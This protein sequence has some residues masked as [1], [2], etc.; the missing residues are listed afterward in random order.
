MSARFCPVSDDPSLR[1][2]LNI[3]QESRPADLGPGGTPV[4]F[5]GSRPR[6]GFSIEARPA[7]WLVKYESPCDAFRA[8]G[9]I[10]GHDGKFPEGFPLT[11]DRAFATVGMMW[12]LSRNAVLRVEA[13]KE[14]FRAWALMGYNAVQLYME[15]V[16]ALPGEEFFGYARGV[17]TPEELREIDAYGHALGLEVM[18]CIQTL[19]HLEQILQW[20]P[21]RGLKDVTG[22]LM[23]GEEATY[24]LIAKMLDTLTGCFR[25]RRIH[26]GM[27]EAHGVGTGA[28]LRK[29]GPRRPFDIL[30][31][32]LRRVTALCRERGLRPMIWSDMY[33]RIGSK[34]N[35][36][37]DR[38]AEIPAEVASAIS[39]EVDLVYWDYYH[40]DPGFYEEWIRRHRTMGK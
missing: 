23:V 19:G 22:V 29:H 17:Y 31:E 18:P 21:Y 2:G 30:N 15:D 4:V 13:V 38:E 36:Y 3:L 9:L 20:P 24:R 8:L 26:I 37:Y 40:E 34:T 39:P 33:F 25:S 1:D 16:Y 14:L 12:D 27:D 10:L 32:H 35:D 5:E 7:G 11:Q 6:P 28:Y